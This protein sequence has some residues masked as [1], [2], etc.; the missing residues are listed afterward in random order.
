MAVASSRAHDFQ[1][2]L[3]RLEGQSQPTSRSHPSPDGHMARLARSRLPAHALHG[4]QSCHQHRLCIGHSALPPL[5]QE[6]LRKQATPCQAKAPPQ[7]RHSS[8]RWPGIF[9]LPFTLYHM[10]KLPTR[11]AGGKAFARRRLFNPPP[12]PCHAPAWFRRAGA[13]RAAGVLAMRQWGASP[14]AF[15]G[16]VAR[17]ASAPETE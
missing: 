2:G 9:V 6:Y 13:S 3:V 14:C 5:T 7:H 1:S 17:D 8:R 4:I 11:I 12:G 10:P 15:F 16:A